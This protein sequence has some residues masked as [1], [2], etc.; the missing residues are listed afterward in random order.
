MNTEEMKMK[1][2]ETIVKKMD[3]L[4]EGTYADLQ[5]HP[6]AMLLGEDGNK[7]YQ[8]ILQNSFT[9]RRWCSRK[10]SNMECNNIDKVIAASSYYKRQCSVE[11]R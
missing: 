4:F 9:D 5:G 2:F 3:E 11:S 6:I 1:K 8:I 7:Y 10:N